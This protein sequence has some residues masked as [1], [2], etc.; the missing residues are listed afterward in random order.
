MLLAYRYD[1]PLTGEQ[2]G[3]LAHVPTPYLLKLMQQLVRAGI[4]HSQRGRGGGFS[5]ASPPDQISIWDIVDAVEP[6]QRISAC[7]LGVEQHAMLCPLHRKVD[8]ALEHV[9]QAFRSTTLAEVVAD[10]DDDTP[11]CTDPAIVKL[12]RQPAGKKTTGKKTAKK[13]K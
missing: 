5:L 11:L 9:E 3:E 1:S 13:R 7:P 4:V 12:S 10:C 2:L 6:F 8:E